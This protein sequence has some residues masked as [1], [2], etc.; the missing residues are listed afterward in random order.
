[1]PIRDAAKRNQLQNADPSWDHNRY[2]RVCVSVCVL[3]SNFATCR[4]Q[5]KKKYLWQIRVQAVACPKAVV[6]AL[7]AT[8]TT[9]RM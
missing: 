7:V 2:V 5:K 4:A 9:L 1:M 8:L 3:A 6:V